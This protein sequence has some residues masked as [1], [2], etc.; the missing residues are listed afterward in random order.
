MARNKHPEETVRRILEVSLALFQEKGYEHTTIQDIVNALGMSKGAV[1]HHFKSKEDIYDRITDAY[2]EQFAWFRDVTQLPGDTGL[3]KM[4]NLLRFLLSDPEKLQMDNFS[5]SL[6]FDPKLVVLTLRSSISD[7]AP[8]VRALIEQGNADGS[9]HVAQPKEMS[10]AF[11][12]LMNLWV[13]AFAVSKEDFLAKLTF[14][15]TVT[16]QAGLPLIDDALFSTAADYYDN[17]ISSS[18][19]RLSRLG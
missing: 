3:A 14:L 4:Q 17:V 9:T 19:D 8:M 15:R 18:M 2:Y 13:G 10:E 11:M 6:T 1:Y 16:D 5:A 12:L 7:S